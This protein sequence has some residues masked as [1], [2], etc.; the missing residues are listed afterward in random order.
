MGIPCKDTKSG[1]KLQA[2]ANREEARRWGIMGSTQFG[3]SAMME[4]K[5]GK[6][7]LYEREAFSPNG[8]DFMV[9]NRDFKAFQ[10]KDYCDYL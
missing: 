6:V 3:R 10:A 4:G 1:R 8:L 2:G 9:G 5:A 7:G